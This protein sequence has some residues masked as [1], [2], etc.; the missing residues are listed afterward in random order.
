MANE[1][2]KKLQQHQNI[3]SSKY[4]KTPKMSFQTQHGLTN[5][6]MIHKVVHPLLYIKLFEANENVHVCP[7]FF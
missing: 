3:D 2:E 5:N 1:D 4:E 7:N 6:F